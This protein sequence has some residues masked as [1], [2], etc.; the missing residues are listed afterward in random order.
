MVSEL[1]EKFSSII[2][3]YLPVA[4]NILMDTT[5]TEFA[6]NCNCVIKLSSISPM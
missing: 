2:Y 5:V 4:I 1:I 3:I 6:I